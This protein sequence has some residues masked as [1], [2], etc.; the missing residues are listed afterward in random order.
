MLNG[1][2]DKK[3]NIYFSILEI[4]F[5]FIYMMRLI[6]VTFKFD[7][8]LKNS[9]KKKTYDYLNNNFIIGYNM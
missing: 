2:S 1:E 3:Y 8:E 9:T 5:F 7:G 6:C 4:W